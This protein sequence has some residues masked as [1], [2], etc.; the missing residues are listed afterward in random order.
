MRNVSRV[1]RMARRALLWVVPSAMALGTGCLYDVR[2][3]VIAAGLDYV[4]ST[5]TLV[6]ETFIPV[7]DL[8]TGGE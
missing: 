4:E 2:Q 6:L 3:S 1:G 7:E 8:I 5:A